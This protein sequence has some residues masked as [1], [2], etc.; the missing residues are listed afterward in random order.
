M[1][2]QIDVIKWWGENAGMLRENF[3]VQ[4]NLEKNRVIVVSAMRSD[5]FN[6][7]S[8]LEELAQ[9]LQTGEKSKNQA[10]VLIWEI[11]KFHTNHLK[12][13]DAQK[14]VFKELDELI[15]QLQ[16]NINHAIKT[17]QKPKIENDYCI[18][19]IEKTSISIIWYGEY[20]S[21]KLNTLYFSLLWE[22][23]QVYAWSDDQLGFYDNVERIWTA[24]QEAL[25]EDDI[26]F[27]PWYISGTGGNILTTIGR[28]YSDASASLVALA[29][30]HIWYDTTLCIEKMVEWFMSAD[31]RIVKEAILIPELNYL[32]AKEIITEKWPEAKLLHHASLSRYIQQAEIS[33]RV[34]NPFSNTSWTAISKIAKYMPQGIFY[35]GWVED[36]WALIY[37][38]GRL[39]IEWFIAETSAWLAHAG[40]SI[41][42][43][44]WSATEQSY[45][46]SQSE[47]DMDKIVHEMQ[48]RYN[49]TA[50]QAGEYVEYR[51][52]Y[53]LIYCVGNMQDIIWT[54][55]GVTTICKNENINI[56]GI[57]QG[58]EQR[59]IMIAVEKIDYKKAIIA[60]HRL[61]ENA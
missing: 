40:I 22:D 41:K 58:L 19:S 17:G 6:T 32:L 56:K 3:N 35:V 60:L 50:K 36:I 39:D 8:Y 37:S 27:V 61:V 34:Y 13:Q 59:A 20:L 16:D 28:W 47:A 26:I 55:H 44:L 49:L 14:E 51:D 21:A 11:H 4:K 1:S 12:E 33:V 29:M 31:P 18:E 5:D 57:A 10:Q 7:T 23:S 2:G 48:Q 45:T 30:K 52:E 25:E 53:S 15:Q 38:S 43:P 24:I 42:E 9:L 46:F 54:L